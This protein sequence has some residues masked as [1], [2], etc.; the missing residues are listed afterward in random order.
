MAHNEAM[1][2]YTKASDMSVTEATA[3]TPSAA[4]T[5]PWLHKLADPY[6]QT[7]Q[8]FRHR[9]VSHVTMQHL[10]EHERH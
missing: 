3:F 4:A 10:D 6:S 2:S 1:G 9:T 8:A 7:C 5:Q